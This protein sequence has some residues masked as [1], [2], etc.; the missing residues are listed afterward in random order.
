MSSTGEEYE[1]T[2][3]LMEDRKGRVWLGGRFGVACHDHDAGTHWIPPDFNRGQ[4]LVISLREAPDGAI[5]MGTLSGYLHRLEDG[6][7]QT[8]WRPGEGQAFPIC[9]LYFDALGGLWFSRFGDGL[10][11]LKDGVAKHFGQSEDVP[12]ATINGI[13]EDAGLVWMTSKVG[14]YQITKGEMEAMAKG[15]WERVRWRHFTTKDGLPSN[16]CH[17]ERSQPSICATADGR[18]WVATTR[19]VAVVNPRLVPDLARG[20]AMIEEV[21]SLGEG[22]QN[23]TLLRDG[24]LPRTSGVN[25]MDIRVPPGRG[26]LVIRYTGIE[27]MEPSLVTF[28]YRLLGVDRDWVNAGDVRSAIYSALQPGD[29][30]FELI[31]KNK[32]GERSEP[33]AL[34]IRVLPFWWETRAFHWTFGVLLAT[35]GPL[36]YWLRV[37]TLQRRHQLQRAFS[38]QLIEREE[39]ERKRVAQQ[40]HDVLGH[41]LLLLKTSAV[42]GANASEPNSMPQGQ[43]E[44]IS[45]IAS[46]ALDETREISRRLRPVELDRLGLNHAL[47]SLLDSACSTAGLRVFKELDDLGSLLPVEFQ[48]HIYRMAQEGL[49]NLMKHARATTVMFE[50]KRSGDWVRIRL[51]DDGVGFDPDFAHQNGGG[52]GLT[53]MEE[54]ARLLGGEF[55]VTSA[56]GKGTQIQVTIPIPSPSPNPSHLEAV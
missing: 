18:V 29:Y 17:G 44:R 11:R 23:L 26:S 49:N 28:Q 41:E 22:N 37:R 6:K 15:Q 25:P 39:L 47:E 38:Q 16:E 48:L 56:P 31:A 46:R 5:W 19:G 36:I 43:F 55:E 40:V 27:F 42:Q 34:S 52:M 45:T 3:A 54:R 9:A 33:A 32:S 24:G 51:E 8:A 50:I 1:G 35:V 10:T 20:R 2:T 13:L 7:F 4:D 14:V 21:H 12:T 30:R 53:G